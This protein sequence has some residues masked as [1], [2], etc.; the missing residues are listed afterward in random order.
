[1]LDYL[2]GWVQSVYNDTFTSSIMRK[3]I[4]HKLAIIGVLVMVALFDWAKGYIDL[5]VLS[6]A[7][8]SGMVCT[9]FVIM[10]V[11]SVLENLHKINE[12][13]PGSFAGLMG[14]AAANHIGDKPCEEDEDEDL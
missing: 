5:G 10:E 6:E 14:F 11:G 9:G 2:S 3:G 8:I 4:F 12:E 1:M 7:P 13:I